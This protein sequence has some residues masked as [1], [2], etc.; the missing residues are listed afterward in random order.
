MW[1][2]KGDEGKYGKRGELQI[3]AFYRE[4]YSNIHQ[5]VALTAVPY[6]K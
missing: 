6:E 1:N 2:D 4:T 3:S 5:I